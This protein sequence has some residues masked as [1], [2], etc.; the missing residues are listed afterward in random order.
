[1]QVHQALYGASHAPQMTTNDPNLSLSLRLRTL[2]AQ[3]FGVPS[4]LS[5]EP[6]FQHVEGSKPLVR[7]TREVQENLDR[8]AADS[9]AL[10]RLL[11]GYAQYLPLL[12]IPTTT[13]EHGDGTADEN[14][15]ATAAE[16]LPDAVKLA[17]VLEAGWD[18]KA[19]ERDLREVDTLRNRG[20]DGAGHLEKMLPY[21]N[22]LMTALKA[23]EARSEQLHKARRD[24]ADLLNRYSTYTSAVS[25]MFLQLHR[26]VETM[27]DAVAGL[28][29][30]KRQEAAARY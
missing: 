25:E 11:N 26:R 12:S 17:M 29:R 4:T 27:E 15:G 16:L 6:P 23:S 21:K 10:K 30:R 2:E 18:I 1:M 28:E 20:A 8:A 3:V 7:R 13:V 9:D 24:V 19:A 5:A 14:G 22:D